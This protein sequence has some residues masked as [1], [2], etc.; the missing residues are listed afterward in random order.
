MEDGAVFNVDRTDSDVMQWSPADLLGNHRFTYSPQPLNWSPSAPNKS[1][2][3]NGVEW[4]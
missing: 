2:G 1:M 3:L 4:G